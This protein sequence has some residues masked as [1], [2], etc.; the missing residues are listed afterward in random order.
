MPETA[1]LTEQAEEQLLEIKETYDIT[2]STSKV[3]E[4][5]INE[6][7]NQKVETVNGN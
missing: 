4:L 6:L 1:R 5:S 2:V 7:Y 3:V